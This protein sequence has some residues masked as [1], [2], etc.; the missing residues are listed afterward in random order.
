MVPRGQVVLGT[1]MSTTLTMDVEGGGVGD[2][3]EVFGQPEPK[4][5][6]G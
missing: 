2:R 3:S 1:M 5:L 4:K 6:A